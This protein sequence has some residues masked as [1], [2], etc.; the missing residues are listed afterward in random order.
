MIASGK[1]TFAAELADALQIKALRSDVVRKKL[2]DRQ[3][4][5]SQDADFGEGIYSDDATSL[6]YGKLLI[7]AQEEI[8][9][10]NSVILDATFS[11][12]H[13]R[14]EVLRLAADMDT[15]I[16]FV[17]C[18]CR[19]EIIRQRLKKRTTD[20]DVSDARLKHLDAFKIR[21]EALDEIS[22]ENLIAIDTEMPLKEN[23][24]DI[25]ARVDMPVIYPP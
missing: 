13:Q 1:S 20:H 12:E 16:I 25:L 17:E 21:Y 9:K 24:T 8:E 4:F 19:E 2:F 6:T 14:R 3:A 22:D 5:E 15:N 10:G 18:R 7:N 11:R 23:M